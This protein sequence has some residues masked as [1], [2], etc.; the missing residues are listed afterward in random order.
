MA[1]T[2]SEK[3]VISIRIDPDKPVYTVTL[4]E[5][6]NLENL[7]KSTNKELCLVV[8][9]LLIPSFVN[10][11][12]NFPISINATL[13]DSLAL[14][15]NFLVAGICFVLSIIFRM[16]WMNDLKK[17][18]EIIKIIKNKPEY[19]A[20]LSESGSTSTTITPII[21]EDELPF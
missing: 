2:V 8:L 3:I 18:E 10:G 11:I 9:G 17:R 20:E 13:V 6:E 1:P 21:P 14:F 16:G 15:L 5:L 19:Q 7:G 4:G 12:S